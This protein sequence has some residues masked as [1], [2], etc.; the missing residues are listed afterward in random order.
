MSIVVPPRG[1]RG[2]ELPGVARVL[3][4]VLQGPFQMA[5]RRFGDRMRVQGRP[6]VELETVGAKTGTRRHVVLGSFPE[7]APSPSGWVVVASN[8][9][10]AR[11]PAW[12]LNLAKHP[13]QV[14]IGSG[15]H[16]VKVAPETLKGAERDQ[17]WHEVIS[18][19]P[20]YGRY[21]TLTDRIIPIVRLTRLSQEP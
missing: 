10:S 4:R 12:F 17:A 20:V 6:L 7:L 21:E 18:L 3:M 11:H 19:S 5:L 16:R 13:D 15:K 1:T 9:G 8:S 14:W 2:S